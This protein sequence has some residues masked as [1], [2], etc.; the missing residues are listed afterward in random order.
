MLNKGIWTSTA[1]KYFHS[2]QAAGINHTS[3]LVSVDIPMLQD[4]YL[5]FGAPTSN[6]DTSTQLNIGSSPAGTNPYRT[7]IKPDFS[8]I[9][10]G[11]VFQSA[12]FYITPIGDASSNA[13]TMDARRCLRVVVSNQATWNVFSTGN[14][15]GTAGCSN[16]TT[17]YDGAVA[18][19]TMTQ[20]ASPTLNVPLQMTM[21]AS[22]LQ[23]LYDGTY[24]NNGI[25]LF[26]DV[27]NAD[28]IPYASTDNATSAYR[29]F[30]TVTYWN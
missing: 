12:I 1:N 2:T 16:S 17:D 6:F 13:R 10:S 15:W 26:V 27:Q 5:D 3:V 22:E 11:I 30:I 24:A 19:G 9:P 29:P 28:G 4:T 20:P 21:T 23:K 14:N 18:I 25:I 7:W 8:S